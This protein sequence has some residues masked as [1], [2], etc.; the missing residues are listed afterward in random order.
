VTWRITRWIAQGS[1]NAS[2]NFHRQMDAPH[3]VF[4]SGEASPA[5]G[6]APP[7]GKHLSAYA[8]QNSSQSR[9]HRFDCEARDEIEAPCRRVFAEQTR[10]DNHQAAQEYVPVGETAP[11]SSERRGAPRGS[12]PARDKRQIIRPGYTHV[13]DCA[14]RA[15]TG[16]LDG[17]IRRRRALCARYASQA[18]QQWSPEPAPPAEFWRCASAG[19]G[20]F[21]ERTGCTCP[22]CATQNSASGLSLFQK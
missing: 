1:E 2:L 8:H 7:P 6:T 18:Q 20:D 15:R 4:S 16:K 3:S 11:D 14:S 12:R 10:K 19:S 5:R 22:L 9:I 13:P 21:S 17:E